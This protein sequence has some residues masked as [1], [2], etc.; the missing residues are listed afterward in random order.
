M[1]R[2]RRNAATISLAPLSARETGDLVAALLSNV[3]LP[4]D[5]RARLL[6]HAGGNPLY[7]EEFVRMLTDSGALERV[8]GEVRL[9]AGADVAVPDTVHAL[10]AARLDTVPAERKALL[11]AYHYGEAL[12]LARAAGGSEAF[13]E[14]RAPSRRFLELAGDRAMNLDVRKAHSHHR[15]A[16]ELLPEDEPGRGPL[17]AGRALVLLFQAVHDMGDPRAATR[18]SSGPSSCW[19]GPNRG[20]S[21]PWPTWRWP[22]T[23][24]S[25]TGW[26]SRR[27][28]PRRPWSSPPAWASPRPRCAASSSGGW[29]ARP[30][31]TTAGCRT[32]ATP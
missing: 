4:G 1:G 25:P 22:T 26:R 6:V 19:R 14:L 3:T 31:A 10:I 32:C 17:L 21:W 13:E 24:P 18:Y 8:N 20:P 11:L 5:V 7:A 30:G 28:S 16:I 12:E 15:R 2:R 27:P 23:G 29:P 9:A